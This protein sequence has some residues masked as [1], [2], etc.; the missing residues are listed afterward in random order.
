MHAKI[1]KL[2]TMVSLSMKKLAN[3]VGTKPGA[4]QLTRISGPISPARA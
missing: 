1:E 2:L 3:R 4:I